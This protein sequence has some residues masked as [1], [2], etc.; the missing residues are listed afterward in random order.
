MTSLTFHNVESSGTIA[1]RAI[2]LAPRHDECACSSCA[3]ALSRSSFARSHR[4]IL[5]RDPSFLDPGF[6][7][8]FNCQPRFPNTLGFN[9]NYNLPPDLIRPRSLFEL[10]PNDILQ[11]PLLR[12]FAEDLHA[13]QMHLGF[14]LSD[15]VSIVAPRIRQVILRSQASYNALQFEKCMLFK[16]AARDSLS[17]LPPEIYTSIV[18]YANTP[19][20]SKLFCS[21]ILQCRI[22]INSQIR[23]MASYPHS[24]PNTIMVVR[25]LRL[26]SE[27]NA[28]LQ[29]SFL[30][31]LHAELLS[32]PRF[33]PIPLMVSEG[34]TNEPVSADIFLRHLSTGASL[35]SMSDCQDFYKYLGSRLDKSQLTKAWAVSSFLYKLYRLRDTA[36][37]LLAG[38]DLLVALL[39]VETVMKRVNKF[40]P[41]L[42]ELW[43]NVYNSILTRPSSVVAE[44]ASEMLSGLRTKLS[45]ILCSEIVT[46]IRNF[47]LSILGMQ[48]FSPEIS[49]KITQVVGPGKSCTVFELGE[50]VLEA[51]I[52]FLRSSESYEEFGTISS[53]FLSKDPVAAYITLTEELDA[54]QTLTYSGLPVDGRICRTEY[55]SKISRHVSDG[56]GL[57]K[58]LPSGRRKVDLERSLK[59]VRLIKASLLNIMSGEVRPMPFAVCLEGLPGIGKGLLVDYVCMVWSRVKGREYDSN[60]IYHRQ[61]AE[62][63]WSGYEPLSKPFIHYSEPGSIHRSI[64]K[65]RGDPVMDEFLSVCDNQAFSCNMADLDSKGKVYAIPECLVMDCN[66]P[67]MNIDV[68]VN[69]P[70]AVRRRI[71]Y[72]KPVV[73]SEFVKQGTCRIDQAKS[74]ASST[75]KLDRWNFTVYRLE[76]I[77]QR[78]SQTITLLQSGDIYA[79]T[80]LLKNLFNE[81]IEQ[82]S[83][84]L[85]ILKGEH[86]D[87]YDRKHVKSEAISLAR[88]SPAMTQTQ[89]NS[90]FNLSCL[91]FSCVY[92]VIPHLGWCFYH[93][94]FI[95]PCIFTILSNQ[96]SGDTT[97]TLIKVGASIRLRYHQR[98]ASTHFLAVKQ[99]FGFARDVVIMHPPSFQIF[100]FIGVLT[101]LL[102]AWKLAR[103]GQR[104]VYS[105]GHVLS[106][107]KERSSEEIDDKIES[108][109]NLSGARLPS[110]RK[111]NVTSKDWDVK[112]LFIPRPIVNPVVQND[113]DEIERAVTRNVR[114]L[115]C[116]DE[117]L[118][119]MVLGLCSDIAVINTHVLRSHSTTLQ[120][121]V[122]PPGSKTTGVVRVT[123]ESS[124][125]VTCGND[126]SLVRLRGCKFRDIR[127][128]LPKERFHP[129]LQG[130][131]MR[132][133]GENIVLHYGGDQM[134]CD[135]NGSYMIRDCY[136]YDHLS[137]RSG[138][139]GSPLLV[140]SGGGLFLCGIHAAGHLSE[141]Y[142]NATPLYMD[143]LG[144]AISD[145]YA[146]TT[147]LPVMSEGRIRMP[148]GYDRFSV[149]DKRSP[150][151]FEKVEGIKI[152]GKIASY[153]PQ[154]LGKS[155]LRS[156]EFIHDAETLTGSSPWGADGL[157]KYAAPPFG[158]S[159][160]A[161]T[162]EYQAPYN[163]Y[164][165]KCG[166]ICKSLS[167]RLVGQ[168]IDIISNHLISNLENRGLKKLAPVTLAV[169]QNGCPHDFYMRSMKNST[170]GGWAYGCK[171]SHIEPT[172]FQWKEDAVIPQVQVKEQVLEQLNAYLR[173]EDAMPLLGA[174]LKDEPRPIEKV[175]QRKTRVFCMSSYE[176]TLVN[177][178]YLMPFYSLMVQH[179]D[180]FCTAIGINMHSTD[181]DNFVESLLSFSSNLM[182]GD[183][184]GFDTSMPYDVGLGANTI[185]YNVLRHFHYNRYAL[186]MVSGICSDNLQP[187]IILRGHAMVVPANQPSGKYGTAED[188]S[189][190]G[191]FMLVYAW[192]YLFD[193]QKLPQG[194][195][196]NEFFKYVLPKIYG[197]DLLCSVKN[198]VKDVYNNCTYQ[199]LC[200]ELFGIDYTS[201]SKSLTMEPFVDFEK[202]SFLKRNFNYR[203][204]LGHWVAPLS[205]DSI[206]K[207]IVYYLPSKSVCKEDQLI[208]SC[209]SALRELFFHTAEKDYFA[210]RVAFAQSIHRR[211]GHPI[212]V[213]LKVFPTFEDIKNQIYP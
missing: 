107:E 1:D 21:S 110:P 120:T 173:G 17:F 35:C 22:A 38:G 74:L 4:A 188:N 48:F 194:I 31:S 5:V 130:S 99:Y 182:E 98:Q 158:A 127:A 123:L 68:L 85:N 109:E 43:M 147:T 3:Q 24:Y 103:A 122:H 177:R 179:S 146:N 159:R 129:P 152:I 94:F 87:N 153:V 92:T 18:E 23:T 6:V 14:Q 20:D 36:D 139:C 125:A 166:V 52:A 185:M 47:V 180:V 142:C 62:E 206:M 164:V 49:K 195:Q 126:V 144:P 54:L 30:S 80:S 65:T 111:S 131:K 70:A 104:L 75:P 112:S 102:G 187:C 45:M 93:S 134:V 200:A 193:T 204:D 189:L 192:V 106:V 181:V 197:D 183:Y 83:S 11:V 151:S 190:R 37:L 117:S 186:N 91:L 210:L 105:E 82:Q 67:T 53:F 101:C 64:A 213:L 136:R 143:N 60:Q 157:P 160:N 170:S 9:A 7:N 86:V 40:Y 162:G 58:H 79:L 207:S 25:G 171:R 156:S 196:V 141:A 108:C 208:D 76:P 135:V 175:L 72:I 13:F 41:L 78:T 89:S 29:G 124:E 59:K 32:L 97:S 149:P 73:K 44:S 100:S 150:L 133:R 161:K 46:S 174:Q 199:S 77:D 2:H 12:G 154:K 69:N 33:N 88:V 15:L 71:L 16:F 172:S 176:S 116:A 10:A 202:A 95:F 203:E 119:T 209:V 56:E 66:D 205:R 137:H 113:P 55:S 50:S 84:R 169:A 96:F 19:N 168:T 28:R 118:S 42:R 163:H 63:Y 121:L 201:A 165:K 184:G 178:M 39:D 138:H 27:T 51:S 191:L 81:H 128:Y 140:K 90:V 8:I 114:E 26:L 211:Y 115:H 198:E 132:Y 155:K 212:D 57:L 34:F 148:P 167:P 145:I 61:S